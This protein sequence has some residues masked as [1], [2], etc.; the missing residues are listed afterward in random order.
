MNFTEGKSAEEEAAEDVPPRE[1]ACGR[2][3]SEQ[4]MALWEIAKENGWVD[5]NLQPRISM[6]KAAIL[7]SVLADALSLSPRWTPFEQLWQTKDLPTN[8]CKAQNCSYYS[9]LMKQ[10]EHVLI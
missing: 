9:P 6:P 8:L 4:A 1:L 3:M 2:L 5:D 10:M 7:A